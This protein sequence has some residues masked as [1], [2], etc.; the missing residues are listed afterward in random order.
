MKKEYVE[1]EVASLEAYEKNTRRHSAKQVEEIG[2]S[3]KQ[4][5]QFKNIVIDDKGT[6]LA[7]HGLVEA[8]K[9][10]GRKTVT[11]LQFNGLTKKQKAKLVLADNRTQDLG[12]DDF[13]AVEDLIRFINDTDIPGYDAEAIDLLLMQANEDVK[14]ATETIDRETEQQFSNSTDSGDGPGFLGEGSTAATEAPGADP[15]SME[16]IEGHIPGTRVRVEYNKKIVCPHC[17]KEV[18]L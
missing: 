12:K 15:E 7:G 8:M 9:A 4:F 13:D 3:L 18:W 6:I 17:H 16:E 1:V 14:K 10:E 2:R 11:A 5:G